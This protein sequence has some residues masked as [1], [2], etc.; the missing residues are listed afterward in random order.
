MITQ[1]LFDPLQDLC[2]HVRFR[3]S[4]KQ[5]AKTAPPAGFVM[6]LPY[7]I[8]LYPIFGRLSTMDDRANFRRDSGEPS[9]AGHL[10]SGQGQELVLDEF[11][12]DIQSRNGKDIPGLG[13]NAR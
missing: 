12:D 6:C 3:K 11:K 13:L 1:H 7:S 10:Q 5:I 4:R 8:I 9:G 2:V